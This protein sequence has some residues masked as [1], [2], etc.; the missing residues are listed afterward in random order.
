MKRVVGNF[1]HSDSVAAIR[2]QDNKAI[3]YVQKPSKQEGLFV[4]P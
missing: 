1:Y 4:V 2:L 3:K